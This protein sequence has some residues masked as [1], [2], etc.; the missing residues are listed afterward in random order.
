MTA[1]FDPRIDD[2]RGG[3]YGAVL[4]FV[5]LMAPLLGWLSPLGF[6]PLAALAGLLCLGAVRA[7]PRHLPAMVPALVLFSWAAVSIFWTPY[8]PKNLQSWI[9]LKLVAESV[10]YWGVVRAAAQASAASRGRALT[11]LA[12]GMAGL[13][14]ILLIEGLTGAFVYQTLRDALHDPIRPDLARRNVAQGAYVLAIF[15]APA[16]LTAWRSGRSWS[17]Y[18]GLVMV[19]GLVAASVAFDADAPVLAVVLALAAGWAVM[20]WPTAGPRV[21]AAGAGLFFLGAPSVILAAKAVGLYDKIHAMAPLSWSERMDY[22]SHAVRWIG[23]HPLR[24]WGIDSSRSFGPGIVLH[25]HDGALQIWLE[26]GVVGAVCA[27]VFWMA[28]FLRMCRKKPDLG[29][30]AGAATGVVYLVFAAVSF[31]VWQ[32]WWVALGG[33]GAAFAFAAELQPARAPA[34]AMV[35]QP[36][37]ADPISV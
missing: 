8:R 23:D 15:C 37:T 31:G 6:A 1:P 25:P 22:W 32:E 26:L 30:A 7:E 21:L 18:L 28:I 19:A 4:T 2:S 5:A 12:W 13:G 14:A 33:L 20:T 16:A 3:W 9:A 27:A 36:S 24:G 11:V 35:K 34:E 17:K 10:L 29:V